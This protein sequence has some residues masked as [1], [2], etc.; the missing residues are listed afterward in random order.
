MRKLYACLVVALICTAAK[1]ANTTVTVTQEAFAFLEG[2]N[3]SKIY[4]FVNWTINGEAIE[5]EWAM[6]TDAAGFKANDWSGA[7]QT[8]YQCTTPGLTHLYAMDSNG[9]QRPRTIYTDNGKACGIYNFAGG[10][11]VFSIADL[12]ATMII[13]IQRGTNDAK[14]PY[15]STHLST[16][17]TDF[18][19]CITDS[20]HAEQEAVD[21][22]GDGTPDGVNDGLDYYRMIADGRI[23]LVFER[24]HWIAAYAVLTDASMAEYV[25]SPVLKLAGVYE[26]MRNIAVTPGT[27]SLGN[28]VETYYAFESADPLFMED[29]EEIA[30]IDTVYVIDEVTGEPA[31]DETTGEKII[32]STT[33]NYVRKPVYSEEFEC[34]GENIYDPEVG[35]TLDITESDD[36]DMDGFVTVK[37][38]SITAE[39]VMSEIVEVKFAV[40]A[41]TLNAPTLT[42]VGMEGTNRNYRIGWTNNTLCGEEFQIIYETAEGFVNEEATIGEIITTAEGVTVTVKA[43]G[44]LD[45][46]LDFQDID[47]E[48]IEYARKNTENATEGKNDW[49]FQNLALEQYQQI[50]GEILDYA[51]SVNA[52]GDTTFYSA[53]EY[54][55]GEFAIPEG[56]VEVYKHFGWWWDGGSNDRATWGV[57]MDTVWADSIAIDA[58]GNETVVEYYT[59]ENVRYEEDGVGIF[60]SGLSID[61]PPNAKNNSCIMIYCNTAHPDLGLYMMAKCTVNI[62]GLNYGEYV[63]MATGWGGSNYVNTT[64]TTCDM[65]TTDGLF[66]KSFGQGVHIMNINVYTSGN[67]PDAIEKIEGNSANY[68]NV[69]S[70]DGRMVRKNANVGTALNGLQ[71]GIY[72]MNGKKYFVK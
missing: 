20:I 25:T 62:E 26:T 4:D 44:Y 30:S 67:L 13:A 15:E 68:A 3:V 58:D 56:T 48:G 57:L 38:V 34:W 6:S 49:E 27:S 47:N 17:A 19:V 55:S 8:M 46:V 36:E 33:I 52:E 45:G 41:I 24:S 71:K 60:H 16:S 12:K 64:E 54:N 14:K 28:D 5:G 50:R 61:C 39:G 22:D 10:G 9:N 65:V 53:E 2:Y 43:N 66:S 70:I 51:Y 1:A 7:A 72:I 42:L 37:A 21:A 35:S 18:A 69:F 31:I 23:D 29:T 11:R 63:T 59:I 40:N 32:E